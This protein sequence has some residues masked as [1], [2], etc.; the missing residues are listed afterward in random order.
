[1]VCRQFIV[2]R[3]RLSVGAVLAWATFP[4]LAGRI[5][6]AA[7]EAPNPAYNAPA[8]Y[9]SAATGTGATLRLSLHNIVSVMTP[10]SYG[11]VRYAFPTTDADPNTAGNILP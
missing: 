6:Y 10:I 3:P 4:L 9:Y 11:D 2:E 1:M 8:N 5:T 7:Y